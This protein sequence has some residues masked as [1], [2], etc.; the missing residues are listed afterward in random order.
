MEEGEISEEDLYVGG[1]EGSE[2]GVTE[3]DKLEDELLD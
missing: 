1:V 2:E 3:E